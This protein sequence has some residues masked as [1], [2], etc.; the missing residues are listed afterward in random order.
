[1]S[2]SFR[3]TRLLL[4]GI[5]EIFPYK[6]RQR[7]LNFGDMHGVYARFKRLYKGE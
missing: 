6:A 1:M 4:P 7:R 3:N 5:I 2:T